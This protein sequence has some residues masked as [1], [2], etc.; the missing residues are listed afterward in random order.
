LA[1]LKSVHLRCIGAFLVFVVQSC[2]DPIADQ[3]PQRTANRRT[4]KA[5]P[6]AASGDRSA[7]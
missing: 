7:D 1:A 2:A 4:G 3:A 6:G 5:I